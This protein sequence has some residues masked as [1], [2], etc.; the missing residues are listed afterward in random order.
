MTPTDF[1]AGLAD[2]MGV[3]QTE[4]A[5]VDRALAKRGLRQIA[6]G[7][8]RPDVT[9]SEGLQIVMAWAGARNLTM[10]AEEVERLKNFTCYQDEPIEPVKP[11]DADELQLYG[12]QLHELTGLSFLAV[13]E[14][15]AIGVGKRGFPQERMFVSLEKNGAVSIGYRDNL[16]TRSLYFV[17]LGKFEFK[18]RVQPTVTLTVTISGPVLKWIY[19]VTEAA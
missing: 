16:S 14:I 15:A 19:D 5:T 2:V 18:R 11:A 13:A 4:L 12:C 8:F 17:D 9:L 6:R 1:V 7:R 3:E 10:A